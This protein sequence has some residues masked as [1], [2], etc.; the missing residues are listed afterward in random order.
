[1]GP[2]KPLV[3]VTEM[4]VEILSAGRSPGFSHVLRKNFA[5]P[6]SFDED[7]SQIANDRR[8]EIIRSKSVGRADCS[9]FLAQR[10][11]DTADN[12]RLPVEIDDAFFDQSRQLQIAIQLEHLIGRERSVFDTR[13]RPGPRQFSRRILGADAHLKR[14]AADGCR[15]F[16]L[17]L[18][19]QAFVLFVPCVPFVP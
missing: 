11:I 19:L 17:V 4:D 2:M 10:T 7:R 5:R 16:C 8:D 12:F 1:M 6:N 18:F 3:H 15:A 14:W 9:R 13:A